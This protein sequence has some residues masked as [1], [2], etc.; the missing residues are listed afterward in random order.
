MYRIRLTTGEEAV[1]RTVEELALAVRSGVVS[2]KAEV[3]HKAANRW[4]P[5][6]L[7]PD[8]QAVASGK[9][10]ALPADDK[11]AVSAK[12]PAITAKSPVRA[13]A[14][15]PIPG[16]SMSVPAPEPARPVPPSP[17]P[18]PAPYPARH[19]AVPARRGEAPV[20][21]PVAGI[22]P[23]RRSAGASPSRTGRTLLAWA[24]ATGAVCLFGVGAVLAAPTVRDWA[25]AGLLPQPKALEEGMAALSPDQAQSPGKDAWPPSAAASVPEAEPVAPSDSEASAPVLAPSPAEADPSTRVSSLRASRTSGVSYNEA[26]AEAR[27]ELEE[28]L[29]Y[30]Q[31]RRVF[32]P[33]RFISADSIRAARRMI[34]AAGNILRAYRGREVMLEQTYR[35]DDPGGRGTLREPFETAETSRALLADADSLF[36]LLVAQQGRFLFD[37]TSL[38]FADP[39]AARLYSDLRRR[40]LLTLGDW[41]NAPDL[42]PGVTIPRL[43][44]ALGAEAPPPAR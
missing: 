25:S 10:P 44:L 31:F 17:L 39:R 40:I 41:R 26:Y 13:P 34:S 15:A 32:S 12:R 36:G 14:P 2:P 38:R 29:G 1:F 9:H 28:S 19:T 3:F 6:E 4:L 20:P 18:P 8:Y 21:A 33:A 24:T 22:P 35:P 23:A 7:H 37:G 30:V 16:P 11:K 42:N 43:I 27:A 5:V